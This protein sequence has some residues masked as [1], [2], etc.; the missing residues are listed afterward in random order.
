MQSTEQELR[1][2]EN[3]ANEKKGNESVAFVPL[4]CCSPVFAEQIIV[5]CMGHKCIKACV[6]DDTEHQEPCK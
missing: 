5:F 1:G 6:I 2:W 4:W 3:H